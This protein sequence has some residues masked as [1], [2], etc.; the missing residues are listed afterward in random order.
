MTSHGDDARTL[1]DTGAAAVRDEPEEWRVG[2][3]LLGTYEITGAPRTGGMGVVHPARHL[4]WGTA[5]AVKSPRRHLLSS[6]AD[7]DSFV[8]EARTW[9][10]LGLHPH[11]CAC[12]YVRTVDGF[13]RVFAEY[14]DGGS[15]DDRM[16]G[17]DAPLYQ[18][19]AGEVLARILDIAVQTVWGLAHAHAQGV[20]HRDVKPG[21]ILVGDDGQVRV[22]D[23][24]L[25]QAAHGHRGTP[26]YRSP[27]QAARNATG[28]ATDVWSLAA[29]V[30]E[31]FTGGG[32]WIDG[33]AAAEALADYRTDGGR[34]ARIWPMPD[35]LAALLER[36][37]A[38]RPEDRPAGMDA[39]AAELVAVHEEV[40]GRPYRRERPVAARLRADELNNRA[41]SLRDLRRAGDDEVRALLRQAL[42]ADPRHPE[43]SFNLG[44]LRWRAGEITGE[45]VLHDLRSAL[46]AA[47]D[48]DRAERDARTGR[49]TALVDRERGAT[50]PTVT[51]PVA[52]THGV[53]VMGVSSDGRH[54]VTGDE[55]GR[56]TLYETT[57]GRVLRTVE[58]HAPHAVDEVHVARDGGNAISHGWD[59]TV[60]LWDLTTGT[61]LRTKRVHPLTYLTVVPDL[62]VVAVQHLLG[63]RNSIRI[64]RLD[65]RRRPYVL[66]A[67]A[68]LTENPLFL[69]DRIVLLAEEGGAIGVW[70]WPLGM[71]CGTLVGH[72]HTVRQMAADRSGRRVVTASG[73]RDELT[74]RVWDVPGRRCLRVLEGHPRPVHSLA[75]SDD[76]RTALTGDGDGDVRLWDLDTGACVRTLEG[77]T[78]LM[79]RVA[80]SDPA[81]GRALTEQLT[82]VAMVWDLST[83][84]CLRTFEHDDV[85]RAWAHL[86]PDGR[87][88]V[89][90]GQGRVVVHSLPGPVAA[91]LQVCRPRSALAAAAGEA[92][93]AELA[94][95]AARAHERGD[96]SDALGLLREARAVPGHERSPDLMA[97]WRRVAPATR[98]TGFRTA[99]Y[100]GRLAVDGDDRPLTDVCGTPDGRY[101][102]SSG[103]ADHAVRVWDLT[104]GGV[105]R[106]LVGHEDTVYTM[107]VTPDGRY[108]LTGGAD[109]TL[110]LWDLTAED[111][112]SGSRGQTLTGHTGALLDVCVT[113]DGRYAVT[114]AADSTIRVWDLRSR[115]CVRTL[116][117]HHGRVQAVC[118]TPDDRYV[119][120]GGSQDSGVRQWDL[121]TGRCVRVPETFPAAGPAFLCLTPD[122][123]LVTAPEVGSEIRVRRFTT[124]GGPAQH[125]DADAYA[126]MPQAVHAAPVNGYVL[127]AGQ[128]D[129]LRLWDVTTC[130]EVVRLDGHGCEVRA[131]HMTADWQHVLGAGSDGAVHVWEADWDVEV[132]EQ[133]A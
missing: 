115:V 42:E 1:D 84:R 123:H 34:R 107:C 46:P 26:R 130:K 68:E 23:F 15:L 72:T 132:P 49:L 118:V 90:A 30:L 53:A 97:V 78:G 47:S 33:S 58:G 32:P 18:G 54:L 44:V 36:C 11:I 8:Q 20:V 116:T 89:R 14:V 27:E 73:D 64:W 60:R 77:H 28:P 61:C 127:T 66:R 114:G 67:G 45:D 59:R 120:S 125:L 128:D 37:L 55:T 98:P 81:T 76:G 75:V 103:H 43:A 6:P 2:T 105:V 50:A 22:T 111:T 4:G 93:V 71:R 51:V 9:V 17:D 82:G 65:G 117:G 86:T 48:E 129:V 102:V 40:T 121:D 106:R 5:V 52:Q 113:S 21:N 122:G 10:D 88:L 96:A 110:R 35:R 131:I 41:L 112:G 83:G 119:L 57:T 92:R 70:E 12:H 16:N 80:F 94:A 104:T 56:I 19:E 7:R 31:M 109:H 91:P 87:H 108:V 133:H 24:G 99:W 13:P 38:L 39:V 74:L 79:E 101:V 85:P 100:S 29:T 63:R 95:R 126:A 69:G 62:R 124:T 25:A 3:R